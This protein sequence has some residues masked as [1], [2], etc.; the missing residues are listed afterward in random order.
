MAAGPHTFTTAE[1]RSP[2]YEV[3]DLRVSLG[4]R[5][6][7]GPLDLQIHEGAFIGMLGPN[8]SG[9]TTLLRAL[10]GVV[11]PSAGEVTLHGAPLRRY[12][13]LEL[14]RLVGV[15]PQQ[16]SLDFGFTVSEMVAMGRYASGGGRARGVVRRAIG[17]GHQYLGFRPLA[18]IVHQIGSV[19]HDP[20]RLTGRSGSIDDVEKPEGIIVKG[21]KF[22]SYTKRPDELMKILITVYDAYLSANRK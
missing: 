19:E 18:G 13:P 17:G 7:L 9:K 1:R 20:F 15:V 22:L 16:F 5:Q 4:G 21:R 10:S 2:V 3:R 8:G 6:V 12:S 14:A 11:K